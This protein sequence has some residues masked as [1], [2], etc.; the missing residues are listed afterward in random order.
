MGEYA[1]LV[2]GGERVKLGSCEEMFYVRVEDINKV[3]YDFSFTA[4]FRLPFPDEDSVCIGNYEP[5]NR[6]YKLK[7]FEAFE[8]ASCPG[9]VY[10]WKDKLRLDLTCY[11]GELQPESGNDITVAGTVPRNYELA[12]IKRIA[13][14]ELSPV[15]RCL[16]CGKLW[17]C[18]WY[19]VM[20]F[21]TDSELLKRIQHYAEIKSIN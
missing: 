17:S 14:G 11:H 6:G 10:I 21:I 7:G 1:K 4:F 9:I 13:S 19:E 2:N 3:D 12:Y 5:F 16:H 18:E 15:V 20:P 8:T